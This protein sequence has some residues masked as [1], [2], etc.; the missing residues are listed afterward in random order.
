MDQK[1]CL[2]VC[3]SLVP[4]ISHLIQ[5]GDFPDVDV[6]SYPAICTGSHLTNERISEIIGKELSSYSKV[7]FFASSCLSKNIEKTI[8]SP[9]IQTIRL[10]Q[11][12]EI[13]LNKESIYY[14]IK[15]GNYLLSNGWLRNYKHR[16]NEWGFEPETAKAFFGESMKKIIWLNT[17]L[18]GDFQPNIEAISEYMGLPYEVFPIGLSHCSNFLN[19]LISEWRA[20]TGRKMLN[21]RMAKITREVADY[22][23][24]YNQLKSLVNYTD[25]ISIVREISQLIEILFAPQ[26]ICY[27]QY[28]NN[29]T[30]QITCHKSPVEA[31]DFN[32]DNSFTIDIEHR[33]EMLGRFEIVSIKF[34]SFLPGYIR[35][36]NVFSQIAGLSISNARKYA[37]IEQAHKELALS[38][39]RFKDIMHQSPSVIEL[40]DL[41]GFQIQ[42]NKAYEELWG[43]PASHTVNRFNIFKSKEVKRVG[44]FDY[45]KRAYAGEPVLV[46]E[47]LFNPTGAT[48]ARGKGRERWLSTRI[49][50][51]KDLNGKV[52]NITLT[53]EDVTEKKITELK[54][55]ENIKQ[56]K[57]LSSSGTELLN[58]PGLHDIYEYLTTAFH[59]Q[60]PN[61]VILFNTIDETES[62]S[63]IIYIKGITDTLLDKTLKLTGFDFSAKKF[64]L[65]PFHAKL[66]KSGKLHHFT[67]G[68][69]QFV[70]N[71]FPVF[72]AKAIERLLGI[73]NIYT[74]GINKGDRLFATIHFFALKNSSITDGDYIESFI[75]QAGIVIERKLL[76]ESLKQSEEKYRLI[77]ENTSDV[78]WTLS[79]D[80]LKFT[81]ISPSVIQLTGFTVE[82]AVSQTVFDALEPKSAQFVMS[83]LP[84]RI[85]EFYNGNFS[86]QTSTNEM[87]QRCKDGS[88]IWVEFTTMFKVTD[89]RI[90]EILGI[91]RNINERKRAEL[92]IHEKNKELVHLNA[93]KDKLFSVIAHDLRNPFSS[94]LGLTDVMISESEELTS[95]QFREYAT[96]LKKT[97]LASYNLLENL[98]DW[99]RLQRGLFIPNPTSISL[100][101]LVDEEINQ[102]SEFALK[103]QIEIE[104]RISGKMMVDVDVKMIGSVIRNLLSNAIKFTHRGGKV[105]VVATK[106]KEIIT[107]KISDNG[108]GIQPN[109][110]SKLFQIDSEKGKPG[111]EGEQSSGLGLLLCKEFVEKN[112]GEIWAESVEGEGSIFGLT[113]NANK[114]TT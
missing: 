77:A 72:A 60:Y 88:L 82:E 3:N 106:S 70:G 86:H 56:F 26:R 62:N 89:G 104:K 67:G 52:K 57:N 27:H 11:C 92:E 96:S 81:Y 87:Q 80:T 49:Y 7:I 46:P 73:S 109:I 47:Y 9:H 40:Y 48:E 55:S 108:I 69:A 100:D 91:T 68:L 29:D 28:N 78:I 45:V 107:L 74:I 111:T 35:M 14:F 97:T 5:T 41:D 12:F 105:T 10:E 21:E 90:V 32:P 84:R 22:S 64:T 102:L 13:F 42:V 24:I 66:F 53:H 58:L 51:L 63:T 25:E 43:F 61:A 95:S 16:Q 103:K 15:Q 18:P 113:L 37:E 83:E 31:I 101:R 34:P 17:S 4:E 38:E 44:L 114:K 23:I 33:G 6:K 79:I 36:G 99:S 85:A 2:F 75:K 98:L 93:E 76:E 20:E 30:V 71:E 65:T 54:L 50:P 8:S 1:L 110:L 112:G 59:Q 94:I 39:E 19:S